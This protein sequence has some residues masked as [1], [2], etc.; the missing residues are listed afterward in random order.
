[1]DFPPF[2]PEWLVNFWLRTPVLN[3]LDPHLVL[4]VISGIVAVFYFNKR[5]LNKPGE[6][7]LREE[8]FQRLLKRQKTIEGKLKELEEEMERES[9]SND[10]LQNKKKELEELLGQTRKE[11][12][13][14][15]T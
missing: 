5:K 15:I 13:Q 7:D 9:L 14:F 6:P 12:Q 10:P 1:M 11:L 4:I 3:Q 2:H 8:R